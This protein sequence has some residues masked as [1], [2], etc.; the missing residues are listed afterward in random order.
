MAWFDEVTVT[1]TATSADSR[2]H[3]IDFRCS[4]FLRDAT[5]T[6][7]VFAGAANLFEAVAR[8]W[9]FTDA[10]F[11]SVDPGPW[12]G[13]TVNLSGTAFEQRGH[14]RIIA[15]SVSARRLR[16]VDG[17]HLSLSAAELDLTEADFQGASTLNSYL[18][19]E[20][21]L[22]AGPISADGM[23]D[24]P[25]ARPVRENAITQAEALTTQVNTVARQTTGCELDSLRRAAVAKLVITNVSLRHCRFADASGL[26][27]IRIG[28]ECLFHRP[29]G[30][31]RTRRDMIAEEALWRES[32]SNHARPPHDV[33]SAGEIAAIYRSLRKSL[34]DTKNEPGAA[35]FYYS[36]MEMRRNAAA[37]TPIERWLLHGYWAVSGYGL[38]A[39][40]A[41]LTLA[42]VLIL[43][44]CLYSQ[45]PLAHIV[46]PARISAVNFDTGAL[47][48]T[49]QST[50]PVSFPD[51]LEFAAQQSIS[52]LWHPNTSITTGHWGTWIAWALHLVC[53][54]LLALAVLALRARIKR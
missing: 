44:A 25:H 12:I 24:Y 40:R 1:E 31:L 15:K 3:G 26:E 52:L 42:A 54:G 13:E 21:G 41:L 6:R 16:A 9:D 8:T 11:D 27:Q 30:R 46:T 45:A 39:S 10:H 22:I 33:P 51:A 35:D 48:S 23:A 53:P 28:S 18:L 38:R 14:L 36:E 29:H 7:A 19:S 4:R 2:F 43:A 37:P 34:E 49:K 5:F 17:T 50:S 47:V 20:E 32:R